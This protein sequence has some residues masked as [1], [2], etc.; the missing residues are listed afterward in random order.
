MESQVGI[1]HIPGLPAIGGAAPGRQPLVDADGSALGNPGQHRASGKGVAAQVEG[2]R[3]RGDHGIERVVPT[4]FGGDDGLVGVVGVGIAGDIAAGVALSGGIV[5]QIGHG[6]VLEGQKD[7]H[8]ITRHAVIGYMAPLRTA[9]MHGDGG[10]LRNTRENR[11]ARPRLLTQV[12]RSA[13]RGDHGSG[14]ALRHGGGRAA[15]VGKGEEAGHAVA[16][17]AVVAHAAP[18]AALL[19]HLH[20]RATRDGGQNLAARAGLRAHVERTV[21]RGHD[22]RAHGGRLR[23]AFGDTVTLAAV[24]IPRAACSLLRT[25]CTGFQTFARVGDIRRHHIAG[26][27]LI[28]DH[29]P[30]TVVGRDGHL[31]AGGNLGEHLRASGGGGAQVD[32]AGAVRCAHGRRG[33]AGRYRIRRIGGG[34]GGDKAGIGIGHGGVVLH[35][36]PGAGLAEHREHGPGGRGADHARAHAA[37]F[38]KVDEV[39]RRDRG[40][41]DDGGS[42]FLRARGRAGDGQRV[43]GHIPLEAAEADKAPGAVVGQHVHDG[44]VTRRANERRGGGLG[45]ADCQRGT[46]AD[47]LHGAPAGAWVLFLQLRGRFHGDLFLR[48]ISA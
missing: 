3:H 21:F 39:R 47:Q 18:G 45:A 14:A 15:A 32:A 9:L 36:G 13:L 40:K 30:G 7:R 25:A 12:E 11:A 43:A 42:R 6:L 17:D 22:G 41:A 19:R 1:H 31:R 48:G 29:A 10:I 2:P 28:A 26:H 46:G 27:A 33:A 8:H 44:A 5:R 38:P 20:Q 24:L 4:G 23:I 35:L 34:N 16:A 37:F